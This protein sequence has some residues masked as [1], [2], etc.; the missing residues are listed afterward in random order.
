MRSIVIGLV[1]APMLVSCSGAERLTVETYAREAA[2]LADTYV[3]ETQGLSLRYQ[4]TV[5]EGV[6]DLVEDQEQ[7]DLDRA[8][9][10]VA[11]QTAAY[12][13]LVDDAVGR[14][15]AAM[16]SLEPPSALEETHHAYV[17][18]IASVR[19]HLPA[20]R[21]AISDA[22]TL[23]DI[24]RSLAGSAYADGQASWTAACQQLEQRIRDLGRGADLK[25]VK[26]ERTP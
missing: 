4:T 25:C 2:T 20:L 18:T 17:D 24:E 14:Y 7:P 21:D 19:A 13:A 8:T 9:E 23:Q 26:T 1:V 3:T 6:R 15:V 16:G 5:Q 11:S 10:L 12:L 22:A